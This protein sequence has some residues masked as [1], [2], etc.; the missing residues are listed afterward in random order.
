[1]RFR[2]GL[3]VG[4]VIGYAVARSQHE[5]GGDEP[6]GRLA[7]MAAHPSAR[8]L[9]DQGRRMA[10]WAGERGAGAIQRTRRS[11]QRRLEARPEDLSMN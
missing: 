3:V 6:G 7:S 5:S 4:F 1:M 11:I 10:G 8:R 9:G 2:T